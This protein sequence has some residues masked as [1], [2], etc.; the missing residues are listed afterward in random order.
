MGGCPGAGTDFGPY[1][2]VGRA[3]SSTSTLALT[4]SRFVIGYINQEFRLTFLWLSAGGAIAAVV[5][6]HLHRRHRHRRHRPQ[7]CPP[8]LPRTVPAD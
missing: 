7:L 6:T 5:C 1:P 4:V 3:W 2:V 8:P